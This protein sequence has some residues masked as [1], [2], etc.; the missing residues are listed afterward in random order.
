MGLNTMQENL[1]RWN[2]IWDAEEYIK[3]LPKIEAKEKALNAKKHN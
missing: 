3:R 2:L 1:N